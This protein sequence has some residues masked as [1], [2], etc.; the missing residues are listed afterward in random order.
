[1]LTVTGCR[2]SSSTYVDSG[3]SLSAFS[4]RRLVRRLVRPESRARTATGDRHDG[5]SV[6]MIMIQVRSDRTVTA[7]AWPVAA[8]ELRLPV[9]RPQARRGWPGIH[10]Q[11]ADRTVTLTDW[12]KIESRL[13]LDLPGVKL[14]FLWHRNPASGCYHRDMT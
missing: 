14:E 4:D 9:L 3:R 1:M 7:S 10:D 13:K 5:D 8:S 6:M 12:K 11:A 2:S